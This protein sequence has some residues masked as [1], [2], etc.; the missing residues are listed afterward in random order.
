MIYFLAFRGLGRNEM[1][2]TAQYDPFVAMTA[3]EV[4]HPKMDLGASRSDPISVQDR[5]DALPLPNTLSVPQLAEVMDST[6]IRIAAY[7][8][9][10]M[11]AQTVCTSLYLM[12]ID[13][14]DLFKGAHPTLE[15]FLCNAARLIASALRIGQNSRVFFDDEAPFVQTQCEIVPVVPAARA[16]A[17]FARATKAPPGATDAA[18]LLPRLRFVRDL[19][20][21]LE[22]LETTTRTSLDRA[23]GPISG[24]RAAL[25]SV[26]GLW[27]GAGKPSD[28]GQSDSTPGIIDELVP[29][30]RLPMPRK[31]EASIRR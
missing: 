21:A 17:A 27:E 5:L 31:G 1:V 29:R 6:L 7:L 13:R 14:P 19:A 4:G 18:D 8:T 26:R 2:H 20:V 10:Q 16:E 30:W 24:A 9:G 22:H 11:Q 3:I 15:A 12:R 25:D 23:A 28:R